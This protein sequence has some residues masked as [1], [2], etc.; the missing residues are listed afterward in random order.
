MADYRLDPPREQAPLEGP[1]YHRWTLPDGQPWTAF[2]R[3]AG[4]FL[5]RFPGLADF[6]VSADGREA[7]CTPVPGTPEET[8]RHL[9]LNQ[10]LPLMLGRQGRLVFH[11][12]AVALGE[13]AVAFLAE[14]G[15][16][17]STLAAAFAAAGAGFLTDDGMVLEPGPDGWQ[18]L[19]GHPSIRLRDDSR[20]A[21]MAAAPGVRQAGKMRLP[22]QA[23]LPHCDRARPLGAAFFLGPGEARAVALRRL[24]GAEALAEW[25]RHAFVLDADDRAWLAAHFEAVGRLAATLPCYRLDYPRRYAQLDRVRRAIA[26]QAAEVSQP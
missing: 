20:G 2:H 7:S 10:V 11:A 21:L 8:C 6:R 4:G 3:C 25:V 17:K 16:G 5:L 12:S 15:R 18:V 23:R 24:S 9:Y 14:S 1:P 26:A 13:G 19:P 22:A